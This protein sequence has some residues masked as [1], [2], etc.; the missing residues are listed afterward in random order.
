MPYIF[1]GLQAITISLPSL[2]FPT[3][4]AVAPSG[5][6]SGVTQT[7]AATPTDISLLSPSSPRDS[8]STE[9]DPLLRKDN[10]SKEENCCCV[11]F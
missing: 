11:V 4:D 9:K 8:S 3:P 5:L 10:E 7:P 2:S 6:Q 1:P